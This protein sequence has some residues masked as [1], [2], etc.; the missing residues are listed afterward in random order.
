MKKYNFPPA[1][2]R[3]YGV[4][5]IC[6]AAIFLL[7]AILFFRAG[8]ASRNSDNEPA[9]P[10]SH[11]NVPSDIM[12]SDPTPDIPDEPDEPENT[13]EPAPTG[14][15][16][17]PEPSADPSPVPD[18]P[19]ISID[20]YEKLDFR[21]SSLFDSPETYIVNSPDGELNVRRGPSTSYEKLG[22]LYTGMAVTAYTIESGW[23]LIIYDEYYAW[24][25][26]NYLVAPE[27]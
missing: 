11:S 17:L 12:P 7:I 5:L 19:E 16:S 18:T 4:I 25:S 24:T 2:K 14:D 21:P 22:T 27:E 6:V 3:R 13:D 23:A 1:E 26:A 15:P 10:A 9:S 20:L 8:A